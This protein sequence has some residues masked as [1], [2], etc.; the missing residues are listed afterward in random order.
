MDE[1]DTVGSIDA[2]ATDHHHEATGTVTTTAV[3]TDGSSSQM[4]PVN[5]RVAHKREGPVDDARD[6]ALADAMKGL[7]CR[8]Q[9]KSHRNLLRYD[10]TAKVT[11]F[12][13]FHLLRRILA[14]TA[15]VVYVV[16][17][18]Q[19]T[20]ATMHVLRGM[21]NPDMSFDTYTSD[22]I[23]THVGTSSI[24]E[25]PLVMNLFKN[26]TTPR[27]NIIYLDSNTS[28][29]YTGCSHPKFNPSIFSNTFTRYGMY[30][31]MRYTVY[32]L[33][34]LAESELISPIIDC[35]Q[36]SIVTGDATTARVIYL[37]RNKVDH[38]SV[39]L[40][41]VS[42]STQDYIIDERSEKGP[43][44]MVTLTAIHDMRE[45]NLKHY[46]AVAVGYPFF[47]VPSFQAYEFVEI[48]SDTFWRLRSI[49]VD[50]ATESVKEVLTASR[51]GFYI[52]SETEQSNIKNLYWTLDKDPRKVLRNL[53]WRGRPILRDSWAWVH[54]IHFWFASQTVLSL[55]VLYVVMYH[56]FRKG[57]IWIGNAF[58][59]I[60]NSLLL[61]GALVLVSWHINEYWTLK[62]FF[63]ANGNAL[64][65]QQ[66]LFIHPEL[67]HA[68]LLNV[69]LSFVTVIG[70]VCRERIDPPF[71]VL[72]FEIGFSYRL[73]ISRW[74]PTLETAIEDFA[75]MDYRLGQVEVSELLATISPMRLW[76]I[77][78]LT[79]NAKKFIASSVFPIA[80]T[81][82]FVLLYILC[83][84]VYRWFY[85]EKV[86]TQT[87]TE[88]STNE[89]HVV[90]QKLSL[91]L[92]EIATG[93]ALQ[94]KFGVI[95]D[96][97]NYLFIKGV[98]YASSDGIYCNGYV[99]ANAKFLVATNDLLSIFAMKITRLRFTNVYVYDVDA[100]DVK[101]TARLVYP[102]T[103]TWT[104]LLHLNVNILK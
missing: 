88:S 83:R 69:Y 39:Y 102:S 31:L 71:V 52:G 59:S 3:A 79:G 65:G 29:S 4:N 75:R 19:A 78:A 86:Y 89:K 84:K 2:G 12:Q 16:V 99:I 36:T 87:M 85:P 80:I 38:N 62:E 32:N 60:S 94:A 95:S 15:A 30:A 93:A 40:M 27:T 41:P 76:T 43:C 66:E 17:G 26:D 63:L 14:F 103:I 13:L 11:S 8:Y 37:M 28:V 96:Y 61:R 42:F 67:M 64:T 90:Q 68:D 50:R 58:A 77:H 22:I 1:I 73:E 9:R 34:F 25:S 5:A 7:C 101:Q 35:S 10:N 74:I 24:R 72:L 33:T 49:P 82:V 54:G 21:E 20:Y 100:N 6:H 81:L 51:M 56:N 47:R 92:F 45:T 97:D 104:D 98:K 46:F 48:T 18:L 57:K 23:L 91:T 55:F 44:L 53:D 70:Y